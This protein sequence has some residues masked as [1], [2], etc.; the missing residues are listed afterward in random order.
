MSAHPG[1]RARAGTR[2]PV[3]SAA[4]GTLPGVLR[5]LDDAAVGRWSSAVVD[6]LATARGRLDEL[7]VFPVPDGDTG[8]NL[9]LTAEAGH[10][11]LEAA[12]QAARD[13]GA[14]PPADRGLVQR[15][16]HARQAT[17][18]DRPDRGGLTTSGIT[19][20]SGSSVCVAGP[21]PGRESW[22]SGGTAT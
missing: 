5:A 1:P 8:T 13:D 21:C 4:P 16:E 2:G 15:L 20:Y 19:G 3:L 10:A 11:A 14:T 9:L 17:W 22:V 12:L 18:V 6:S 7:N